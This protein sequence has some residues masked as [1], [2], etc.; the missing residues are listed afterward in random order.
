M[1]LSAGY[2]VGRSVSADGADVSGAICFD[3]ISGVGSAAV[4][5]LWCGMYA[6]MQ[7]VSNFCIYPYSVRLFGGGWSAVCLNCPKNRTI[8]PTFNM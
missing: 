5:G 2:V 4:Y 1:S 7:V 3:G 8:V 6:D